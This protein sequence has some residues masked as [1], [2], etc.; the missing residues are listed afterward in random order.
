MAR[1]DAGRS[2][3]PVR[4]P[5]DRPES[6]R[7]NPLPASLPCWAAGSPWT[8]P[9]RA[10]HGRTCPGAGLVCP[11]P[12]NPNRLDDRRR[13]DWSPLPDRVDAAE[14]PASGPRRSPLGTGG[15]GGGAVRES[16]RV[17]RRAAQR[18]SAVARARSGRRSRMRRQ[19]PTV[20]AVPDG[21]RTGDPLGWRWPAR[22]AAGPWS[23][24]TQRPKVK[25]RPAR[26]G[27]STEELSALVGRQPYA[28]IAA[29]VCGR[30]RSCRSTAQCR[31]PAVAAIGWPMSASSWVN[32]SAAGSNGLPP[33]IRSNSIAR[34]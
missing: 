24:R 19:R 18:R 13:A 31:L 16:P 26:K 11:R 25:R 30:P 32:Q 14:R 29:R 3:G 27:P 21:R 8:I 10:A 7:P 20:P 33:L 34:N 5:A 2:A 9:A 15:I 23:A 12:R 22:P 6:V 1:N 17:G 28:R 4:R